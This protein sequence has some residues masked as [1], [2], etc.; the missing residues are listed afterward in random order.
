[1]GRD[2]RT[3]SLLGWLGSI[4]NDL[5]MQ[6]CQPEAYRKQHRVGKNKE[7]MCKNRQ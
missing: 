3:A 1:M 5:Q 4:S 7:K 2:C 6:A